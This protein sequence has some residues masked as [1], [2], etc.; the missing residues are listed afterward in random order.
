M[1]YHALGEEKPL[2]RLRRAKKEG[3][4]RASVRE[5]VA[6]VRGDVL[7]LLD[8][9][10]SINSHSP[11]EKGVALVLE[12]A[13]ET[14]PT[15]F[16]LLESADCGEDHR[17]WVFGRE[18]PDQAPLLLVG[19]LDTVFPPGEF[20]GGLV[21][22]GDFLR[23]PG[24]S[25]MKGGVAVM[26]GALWVLDRLGLLPVMSLVLALNGD[27]EIG[28]VCSGP[29]LARL[30]RSVRLGLVFERGG[31]GGSLVT[32]RRGLR[33][34]RLEVAGPGGHSGFQKG[35]KASAVVELAH[36][37]LRME[38]FNL[39]KEGVSVNVGR[40]AGGTGANIVPRRAEAEFEVRFWT[41][42]SGNAAA[43]RIMASLAAPSGPGFE[44]LLHRTHVRPAMPR[45]PLNVKLFKEAAAVAR[46]LDLSLKEEARLGA[47]DA[48]ILTAA[49]LPVL[50][51]L[52]PVGE[53][54]HSLDE[55]VV[56]ESLFE[57][58][59]FLVHLLWD[60]REWSP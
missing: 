9:M 60:L 8:R 5:G 14:L 4:D 3:L 43:E 6:A 32:S 23:G 11:N 21:E 45:S 29:I 26:I 48:N 16:A 24:V 49:G 19:H 18:C 30:A 50:D 22:D 57:R 17:L 36:Q 38:S 44:H 13:T 34:Y 52:G 47:S 54:D 53:N 12:T 35:D 15:L 42:V 37:I 2:R 33:R 20:D 41:D 1:C 51:G 40:I 59:E 39:P 58:I 46:T 7:S 55:R 56:R 10:V 27:E 28:S 25:D 31:P